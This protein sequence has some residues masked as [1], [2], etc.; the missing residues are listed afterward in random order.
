M[1]QPLHEWRGRLQGVRGAGT[2]RGHILIST[3]AQVGLANPAAL[4]LW[5]LPD[6]ALLGEPHFQQCGGARDEIPRRWQRL[7]LVE[8]GKQPSLGVS[9]RRLVGPGADAKAVQG[10]CWSSHERIV[11]LPVA[12]TSVDGVSG[13]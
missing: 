13:R 4:T 11:L 7:V 2:H 10:N 12:T 8:L 1:N 9:G 6:R 5:R 3:L